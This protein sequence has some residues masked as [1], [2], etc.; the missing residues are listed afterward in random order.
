[1]KPRERIVAGISN[2]FEQKLEIAYKSETIKRDQ[3]LDFGIDDIPNNKEYRVGFA[4]KPIGPIY[5]SA[6]A[7][8]P[9]DEKHT[10]P[11][12]Y[13]I[14]GR[15]SKFFLKNKDNSGL[16]ALMSKLYPSNFIETKIDNENNYDFFTFSPFQIEMSEAVVKGSEIKAAAKRVNDEVCKAQYY[17]AFRSNCYSASIN[18]LNELIDEVDDTRPSFNSNQDL[19]ALYKLMEDASK[20]NLS[21]GVANNG[22]TRDAISESKETLIKRGLKK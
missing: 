6:I 3:M 1:M 19:K 8:T 16:P 15:Q 2:F 10:G 5:H 13:L 12:K 7:F 20:D 21:I 9:L 11:K 14:L 22:T 18:L 4:R 17:D